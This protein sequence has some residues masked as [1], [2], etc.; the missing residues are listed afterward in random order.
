MRAGSILGNVVV[1]K[2][3]PTLLR[4]EGTFVGNLDLSEVLSGVFVRTPI[5]HAL[6]TGLDVS[7]AEHM[8]GVVA[9]FT[10]AN[11]DM[12]AIPGFMSTDPMMARM[13]LATDR[14]RFVGE[15]VALVVAETDTQATDAAEA[16]VVDYDPLP[17]VVDPVAATDPDAPLVI[18]GSTSNV[19]LSMTGPA[20]DDF[21]ADAAKVVRGRFVNP[22]MAAMPME[23]NVF[24]AEPDPDVPG[25]FK[26]W[27]ATQMPHGLKNA[28]APLL[29]LDPALVRVIAPHVGGG[30]GAK[31]GLYHEFLGIARASQRLGRAVRWAETRSENLVGL[32]QGRAQIHWVEMG[33]TD[34][35][36]I[37]GMRLRVLADSGAYPGLAGM[38][39]GGPTRML[40]QGVY[41]IPKLDY[42]AVAVVTN[43]TPVGAFRGAGRPEATALLE[44]IMDMAAVE[45]D[46]DPAEIRRRNFIADD[47]F[48]YLTRTG[49]TYDS[50]EY[51]KPL[52]EALALSGYDD[53]R[54]EQRARRE[55]GDTLQLGIGLGSYVEITAGGMPSEFGAVEV[56]EDGTATIR[57]GTSAHGQGHDT[58]FSM[59]VSDRL[60]IAMDDI[61]FIQSDTALVPMGSG[62]GGSRSLQIGGTAVLQAA[63]A[64]L[65]KAK[66]LV[67]HLL[68]AAPEDIVLDDNGRLAV[69]GVP[70][71]GLSW[72]EVAQAASDPQRRPEGW[73]DEVPAGGEGQVQPDGLGAALIFKQAGS[74]FPFGTHVAVVEVDTETGTDPPPAPH[75]GGRLRLRAQSTDRRRPA[76]RRYRGRRRSGPVRGD[77][78]RQRRQPPHRHPHRLPDAV[79]GRISLLRG[80]EHG[81]PL[82]AQPP[83]GQGHRRSRHDRGDAGRA[84]RGDR[85]PLPSRHPPP[86][87]GPVSGA[88]LDGHRRRQER[89]AGRG[90]V[91]SSC[92]HE[93]QARRRRRSVRRGSGGGVG[94]LRGVCFGRSCDRPRCAFNASSATIRHRRP[95]RFATSPVPSGSSTRRP[96]RSLPI[97]PTPLRSIWSSS[98]RRSMRSAPSPP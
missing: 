77:P 90:V 27:A 55:R 17:A 50:G 2:E 24:A 92:R 93:R 94:D 19:V 82:A 28:M 66:K 69:A 12:G 40:A 72:S 89:P 35:A 23:P 41:E 32:N 37:T 79:G 47:A 62:T 63:D 68:E 54:K 60:G 78:V 6:I 38:L 57:V 84:E 59:L 20:D 15:P 26:L 1:R 3:D 14:V 45:F 65:A 44:R 97:R 80:V 7:E 11:L 29:G 13:P 83:R 76:A 88:D 39:A 46:L 67:G 10:A 48:P 25:G 56:L 73:A 58:S 33:F 34:D 64:V 70:G 16:V 61:R 53:L 91:G 30:F 51:P 22:R 9:I 74:S 75:R 71:S 86:G 4:G 49:V 98:S 95:A 81:N 87:H 43:T 52:A 21:F 85:R 8:P 42:G 5:A 36:V 18:P 96:R 31:A